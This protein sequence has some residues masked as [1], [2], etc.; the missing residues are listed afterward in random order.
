[1]R[2]IRTS[3]SEGGGAKSI[4]SPYPYRMS[5]HVR[6]WLEQPGP[7]RHECRNE[8]DC[9]DE[10]KLGRVDS[11]IRL[12][13]DSWQRR[14]AFSCG[15]HANEGH[16]RHQLERE[17]KPEQRQLH[18]EKAIAPVEGWFLPAKEHAPQA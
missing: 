10:H 9:H 11:T 4:V 13:R 3:S 8:H 1:M 2:E 18:P 17:H 5:T 14:V 12:H 15:S 7:A 16:H 6:T